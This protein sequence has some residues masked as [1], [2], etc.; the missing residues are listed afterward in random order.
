MNK[1]SHEY[2][3]DCSD[4]NGS[5]SNCMEIC[6]IPMNIIEEW[7][8]MNSRTISDIEPIERRC[9]YED[10]KPC[11]SSCRYSNT[12]IHSASKTEE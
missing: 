11:N 6:S 2:C 4:W 10:N 5:I 12:C 8:K 3:K 7:E 1:P 9:V